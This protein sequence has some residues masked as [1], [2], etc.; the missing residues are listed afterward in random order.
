MPFMTLNKTF[1]IQL[2]YFISISSFGF[3][4]L[5]IL[6]P[7]TDPSFRPTNLDLFY[8]S[9][10]ASTVSSMSAM[11]MEVFSN[12]QLIT[13]TILMFLGG[14]IFTSMVGL[15]LRKFSITQSTFSVFITVSTLASCGYVPTN[16]NMV[17]FRRNSG[18]L[19]MLI[20]QVLVGNTL[21]PFLLRILI[22]VIGRKKE[23]KLCDYLLKNS[24]EIGYLPILNIFYLPPYTSFL[25]LK[26]K[27]RVEDDVHLQPLQKITRTRHE[28]ALQNFLLSHLSYLTIFI[29]VICVIERKN[30]VEDPINFSVFN[31]LLEVIS[32]YGNVGFTTGYSCKR[33]LHPQNDCVDKWYGFSG[34]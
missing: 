8:T 18:L 30:M 4:I 13:L 24:E 27:E 22:W 12:S 26:D 20:P 16:E 21:Y 11:K 15:H 19:L 23:M 29:I 25:P 2:F 14:E 17:V 31:I 3:L 34:K 28:K 7:R 1:W 5:T 32:A 10:S 6:K 9:V 33:Q